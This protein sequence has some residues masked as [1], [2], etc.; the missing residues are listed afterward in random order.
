MSLT[1]LR[2]GSSRRRS[3]RRVK[4]SGRRRTV[5]RSGAAA[6]GDGRP[7]G[8]CSPASAAAARVSRPEGW[9]GS[10]LRPE[11]IEFW[12]GSPD[13]LHR[14]LRYGKAESGWRHQRLQP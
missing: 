1:R 7:G 2:A 10:L 12:Y 3:A 5:L 4:G 9:S 11:S 8:C 6:Q 14:R 13:R